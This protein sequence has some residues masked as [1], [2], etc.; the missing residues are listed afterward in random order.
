MK[1][2]IITSICKRPPWQSLH[3]KYIFF[4]IKMCTF[5]ES[6]KGKCQNYSQ[7]PRKGRGAPSWTRG[8]RERRER[9]P[10]KKR[11]P[12]KLQNRKAKPQSCWMRNP[13]HGN[14]KAQQIK[15][16]TT[17]FCRYNHSPSALQVNLITRLWEICF[18]F[19]QIVLV[20]KKIERLGRDLEFYICGYNSTKI[21]GNKKTKKLI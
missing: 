5:I 7:R 1:D 19:N 12:I 13:P 2:S 10:A 8:K 3:S 6:R 17:Y 18:F 15:E 9:K 21:K 4:F 11:E 20:L 16:K 14:T